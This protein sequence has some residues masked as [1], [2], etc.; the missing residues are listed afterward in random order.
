MRH[1]PT[2]RGV[3]GRARHRTAAAPRTAR[4]VLAVDRV[5]AGGGLRA[6]PRPPRRPA[7]SAGTRTVTVHAGGDRT[8]IVHHAASAAS[9]RAA[10]GR[11]ARRPGH[12]R[13]HAGEP[14]LG[15][16]RRPGGPRRRLP[17]RARPHVERGQVLRAGARPGGRRRRLPRHAGRDAAP[18]RR[19]RP[20][21]RRRVLQRR[22]DELRVG[23]RPARGARRYRTGGGRADRR[24]PRARAA[25]RRGRTRDARRAGAD[26]RRP[27]TVRCR[28]PLARRLARPVPDRRRMP[29]DRRRGRRRLQPGS[30]S[31]RATGTPW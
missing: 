7:R 31:G 16:A 8:A 21:L 1:A 24:L 15:R 3:A 9:R 20:G 5:A 18:G 17:R 14:G 6:A 13:R 27:R 11:A 22:D 19:R 25:D 30:T 23:L 12:R 10:R 4:E 28:L 26:R 29:G 2:S